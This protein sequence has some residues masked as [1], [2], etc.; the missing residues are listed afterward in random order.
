MA[1]PHRRLR[2]CGRRIGCAARVNGER[3]DYLRQKSG[4]DIRDRSV[5]MD[6]FSHQF[7]L[8]EE[9]TK[10]RAIMPYRVF[11]EAENSCVGRPTALTQNRGSVFA[12]RHLGGISRR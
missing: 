9:H 6:V 5:S 4:P 1:S 2:P 12:R 11:T 7:T 10:R 8:H 3:R